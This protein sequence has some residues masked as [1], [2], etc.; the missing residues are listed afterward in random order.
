MGGSNMED[1][2]SRSSA[3]PPIC[4]LSISTPLLSRSKKAPL[5]QEESF[6]GCVA[7]I[8]PQKLKKVVVSSNIEALLCSIY[9]VDKQIP[10]QGT[11]QFLP[12][13]D[14]PLRFSG[15]AA[16]RTSATIGAT[17]G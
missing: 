17:A 10:A 11:R 9:S 1:P 12:K 4:E 2:R 3:I 7:E 15:R 13:Y 16:R 14:G 5:A 8:D 6:S